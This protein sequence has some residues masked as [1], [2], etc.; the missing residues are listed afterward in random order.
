M[1]GVAQD[2]LVQIHSGFPSTA[3]IKSELIDDEKA[4][5]RPPRAE[6]GTFRADVW[7]REF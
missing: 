6:L 4:L 7:L 2:R 1:E 3:K 5:I